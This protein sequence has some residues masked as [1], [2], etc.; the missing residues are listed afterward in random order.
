[1]VATGSQY[2]RVVGPTYGFFGFGLALFFASQGA[3]KLLWPLLAGFARLIIA[4]GGGWLML[5]L[6]GS[7]SLVFV[8]LSVALAVYGLIIGT[9]ILS[10]VWFRNGAVRAH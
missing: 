10:G 2:L 3:G 4:V 9:A 5:T 8:M 1:M 7:L 6:I